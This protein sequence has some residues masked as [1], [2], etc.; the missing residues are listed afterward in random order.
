MYL[1][2]IPSLS[3]GV[4]SIPNVVKDAS[5]PSEASPTFAHNLQFEIVHYAHPVPTA[6]KV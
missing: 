5:L 1:Y 3:N 4:K 2:S 6:I